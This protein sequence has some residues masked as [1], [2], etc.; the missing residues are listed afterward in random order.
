MELKPTQKKQKEGN[1]CV[2][3]KSWIIIMDLKSKLFDDGLNSDATFVDTKL[4]LENHNARLWFSVEYWFIDVLK[5]IW[6]VRQ[7]ICYLI[8]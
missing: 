2:F 8:A 6:T 7:L 4:P 1:F 3:L 5:H